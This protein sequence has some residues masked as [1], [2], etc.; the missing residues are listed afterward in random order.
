MRGFEDVGDDISAA[1]DVFLREQPDLRG[2][3]LWGLCDGASACLMYCG[4][5]PRVRGLIL[6]NPWVRTTIGEA[7]AR[8]KHYYLRRLFQR[9]FWRAVLL[10]QYNLRKSALEF[11][12][13]VANARS[14]SPGTNG[15]EP[16]SFI[17]RMYHGL[18]SF[19]GPVLFLIS[20]RDLTAS[21]FVDLC[22]ES[23]AWNA[24]ARRS[25]AR[26]AH[27]AGADHTFS[28]RAALDRA[29]EECRRW[30]ASDISRVSSPDRCCST[31]R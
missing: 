12:R 27:L 21:E 9:S 26:F 8:I 15:R 6:V 19:G 23:S 16:V 14:G 7:R 4:G 28:T 1:V 20:E 17:E 10:G 2:V 13:S 11:F 3:V 29:V 24:L 22:S 25:T 31:R 30:L 5:A 18:R